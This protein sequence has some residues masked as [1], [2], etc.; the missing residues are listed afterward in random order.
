MSLS[1]YLDDSR[2]ADLLI[3]LLRNAGHTVVSPRDTGTHGWD[4]PDHL[5]FAAQH[6]YVLL[7]SDPDDFEDLHDDWQSQGRQH[8]GMFFVHYEGDVTKDM[9]PHD[10]VRA[11]G[12]LLTAGVPI[13]NQIHRLNHWR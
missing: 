4:D 9:T 10:I 8:A 12:N 13:A 6:G 1:I 11:I 5:E 2:D 7:T 3:A